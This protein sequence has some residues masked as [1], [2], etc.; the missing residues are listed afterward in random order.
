MSDPPTDDARLKE[1]IKTAEA[2]RASSQ[3]TIDKLDRLL[4]GLK[5]NRGNKRRPKK[6][7]PK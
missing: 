5:G 1:L 4:A 3:K 7:G 6:Y 2:L